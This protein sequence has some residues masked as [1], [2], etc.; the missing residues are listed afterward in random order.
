MYYAAHSPFYCTKA[1]YA[2]D[3]PYRR[4][5]SYT[6]WQPTMLILALEESNDLLLGLK[7]DVIESNTRVAENVGFKSQYKVETTHWRTDSNWFEARGSIYSPTSNHYVQNDIGIDTINSVIAANTSAISKVRNG[8]PLEAWVGLSKYV[9]DVPN[10]VELTVFVDAMKCKK[11]GLVREKSMMHA[12]GFH[13]ECYIEAERR[14]VLD[15]GL[16]KIY[17]IEEIIAIRAAALTHEIVPES[18]GVHVPDWVISAIKTYK[19]N[20]DGYAGLT[21]TEYL[22]MINPNG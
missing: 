16:T 7:S 4:F 3:V 9:P 12:H 20:P 22:K 21:L 10:L 19:S 1:P 15:A 18:V 6:E 5:N 14:R 8:L 11:C 2:F 17:D 13:P